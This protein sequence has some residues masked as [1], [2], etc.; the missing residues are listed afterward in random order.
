MD[1]LRTFVV[2][3][4]FLLVPL[5]AK[6]QCTGQSNEQIYSGGNRNPLT[7]QS[8]SICQSRLGQNGFRPSSRNL[9]SG[10]THS[11]A[12]AGY[13]RD[14]LPANTPICDQTTFPGETDS[15]KGPLNYGPSGSA[16]YQTASYCPKNGWSSGKLVIHPLAKE[17]LSPKK[18]LSS[19]E[20]LSSELQVAV[21]GKGGIAICTV[22]LKSAFMANYDKRTIN[23]QYDMENDGPEDLR[24]FWDIPRTGQLAKQFSMSRDEP[25][26]LP[27]KKLSSIAI[28]AR[29]RPVATV[30]T[31]FIFDSDRKLVGRSIV[32]VWGVSDGKT[33]TDLS[34]E[35][36][37][38]E[39]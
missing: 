17:T 6:C 21:R 3:V 10:P 29:E 26:L 28:E 13:A 36:G 27:P 38:V 31:F 9:P 22:H 11:S 19:E 5:S 34:K 16:F 35:W 30:S 7:W 32:G 8:A 24:I 4:G 18:P 23:Y 1:L 33:T 12:V 25:H 15:E 20:S 14:L 37:A 2:F 39:K